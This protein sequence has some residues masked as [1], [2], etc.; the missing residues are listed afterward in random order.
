MK[1]RQQTA[2]YDM[3]Q[4][5]ADIAMRDLMEAYNFAGVGCMKVPM[6]AIWHKDLGGRPPREVYSPGTLVMYWRSVQEELRYSADRRPKELRCELMHR[7]RLY[8]KL[9]FRHRWR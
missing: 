4:V 9:Y 6:G 5:S 7:G 3:V 1:A 2:L 8:E